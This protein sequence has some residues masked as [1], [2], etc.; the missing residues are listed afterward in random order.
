MIDEIFFHRITYRKLII[1]LQASE[2]VVIKVSLD[3]GAPNM[4]LRYTKGTDPT[5]AAE[6]FIQVGSRGYLYVVFCSTSISSYCCMKQAVS[7]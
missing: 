4:E 3:D 6:Q 7:I 1:F 5:L 2:T